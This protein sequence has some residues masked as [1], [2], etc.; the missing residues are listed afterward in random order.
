MK[1]REDNDG[2]EMTHIIVFRSYALTWICCQCA[3]ELSEKECDAYINN[4]T[5]KN[6]YLWVIY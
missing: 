3:E 2:N 4:E 5:Y 6:E 1:I